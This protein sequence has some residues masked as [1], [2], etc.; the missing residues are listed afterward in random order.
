MSFFFQF[1]IIRPIWAQALTLPVRITVARYPIFLNLSSSPVKQM[2]WLMPCY[3][4]WGTGQWKAVVAILLVHDLWSCME[5]SNHSCL[6]EIYWSGFNQLRSPR[7]RNN[8]FIKRCYSRA[9]TTA[10]LVNLPCGITTA[11]IRAWSKSSLFF[12]SSFLPMLTDYCRCVWH[13][14]GRLGCSPR[15]LA[16]AM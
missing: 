3:S 11:C 6:N 2:C 10:K 1:V 16:S 4:L 13:P 15:L 8:G 14:R 7:R 9:E 12:W 5:A